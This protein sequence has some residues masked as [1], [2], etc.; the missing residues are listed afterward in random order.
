MNI[1]ELWELIGQAYRE[2]PSDSKARERAL[3]RLLERLPTET[4]SGFAG[5]FDAAIDAA[6]TWPLWGAAY[7]IGGGCSDDTFADFRS[8]LVSRGRVAYAQ[9]VSAPDSLAEID[10]DETEWFHE[11]FAYVP[12]QALKKRLGTIKIR[13]NPS[14][15]EPIGVPWS[16]EDL[17]TLFPRLSAKYG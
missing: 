9:S 17:P 3:A 14:P 4:L 13:S 5:H 1:D 2:E 10:L 7:V 12:T 16:E 6:Y 11:G 15:T 8:A